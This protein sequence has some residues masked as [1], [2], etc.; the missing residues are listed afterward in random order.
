MPASVASD[1]ACPQCGGRGWVVEADGGAGR[2][3]RCS[4]Q[5]L[6]QLPRLLARAAIPARYQHCRLANF[7]LSSSTSRV[8]VQ[9]Q[10]AR[11]LAERYVEEFVQEGGAYRPSGLLF[12]GPPGVG[13]THLAVGVLRELTER[14]RL[15]ARFVEL[16]SL[17]LQIQSSFDPESP[18]TKAKIL[19]PLVSAELLLLD[20]LGGQQMTPWVRDVLY[21]IVNGRYTRRRPTLFTTNYR[22]ERPD[23]GAAALAGRGQKPE[24]LDRGRDPEP[25][26]AWDESSLSHRLPP[27]L[28]SRLFE[29]AQ[30]V[31]LDAVEDFRREHAVLG[32][33]LK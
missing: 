3:R 14:Y 9:L 22:L 29:M 31:V 15:E 30:P 5:A 17:L 32:A 13:K 26:P 27:M 16:T 20:E 24:K 12:I 7:H 2:A 1:Q 8:D 19:D 21:L 33:H 25:R 23:A 18:E 28:V 11:R 4:C 6:D 10:R